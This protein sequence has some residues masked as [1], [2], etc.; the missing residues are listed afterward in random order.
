MIRRVLDIK[1]FGLSKRTRDGPPQAQ[2]HG[3]V[4]D[5]TGPKPQP[6]NNCYIILSTIFFLIKNL[7]TKIYD[8][9]F[10]GVHIFLQN[11]KSKY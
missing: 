9:H 6:L 4:R 5:R 11:F 3:P 2:Q 8:E 1:R 10:E 7:R